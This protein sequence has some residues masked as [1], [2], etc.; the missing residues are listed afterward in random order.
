MGGITQD[1]NDRHEYAQKGNF[2]AGMK[3]WVP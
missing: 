3:N 2:V 1:L